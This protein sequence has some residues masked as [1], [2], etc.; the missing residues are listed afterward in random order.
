[1]NYKNLANTIYSILS[2]KIKSFHSSSNTISESNSESSLL[3]PRGARE[4][5]DLLSLP[6]PRHQQ[7]QQIF[8]PRGERNQ[9]LLLDSQPSFANQSLSKERK[10]KLAIFIAQRW[11]KSNKN[12][13]VHYPLTIEIRQEILEYIA[14]YILWKI[15]SIQG[16]PLYLFDQHRYD[17]WNEILKP[18]TRHRKICF[19]DSKDQSFIHRK[20]REK[21]FYLYCP[22]PQIS[23]AIFTKNSLPLAVFHWISI[24]TDLQ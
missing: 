24:P 18:E 4:I 10:L 9:D 15:D 8:S 22:E 6:P 19:C 13:L 23:V 16:D 11:M 2:D 21:F 3:S 12:Q 1:M 7:Q 14:V 17:L 5:D 20:I